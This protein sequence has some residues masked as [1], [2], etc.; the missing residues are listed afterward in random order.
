MSFRYRVIIT[1]ANGS[2][3]VKSSDL[4][5]NTLK[6]GRGTNCDIVVESR[7]V[8]LVH[9]VFTIDQQGVW[10]EDAGSL[11]GVQVDGVLVKRQ[12]LR[13]G[14]VVTLADLSLRIDIEDERVLVEQRIDR[15]AL[16]SPEQSLRENVAR[17]DFAAKLPIPWKIAAGVTLA[18]IL[19]FFLYP[20]RRQTHP[21]WVAG[22]SS[23][24]HAFFQR[25]CS[26]CHD[27]NFSRVSD[28]K[29]SSCHEMKQHAAAFHNPARKFELQ[30]KQGMCVDCH[31]EHSGDRITVKDSAL[32]SSCHSN[33]QQS[34]PDS[35]LVSFSDFGAH[36]EFAITVTQEGKRSFVRLDTS[37]RDPSETKFNHKRH[38]SEPIEGPQGKRSLACQECHEGT[39]K[40][41]PVSFERHC[42]S[43][44]SLAFDTSLPDI[45]APHAAPDEV[46]SSLLK[47]YSLST[48]AGISEH[49][50]KQRPIPGSPAQIEE[51]RRVA[52]AVALSSARTA[53]T[54]LFT[55]TACAVC[56]QVAERAERA[57]GDGSRF[58]VRSA[59]ITS[60]W[61]TRAHFSHAAHE[62]LQCQG[63]HQ[64][65]MESEHTSELHMPSIKGCRDCHSSLGGDGT[66][67]SDCVMCHSYH[68]PITLPE[69]KKIGN[70]VYIK[71]FKHSSG[72]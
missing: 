47:H 3:E 36:P 31:R 22:P 14:A 16:P 69:A 40:F 27:G 41:A 49:S 71:H 45:E 12:L 5:Q 64:G 43:C 50:G 61:F 11:A 34:V 15:R 24:A 65:I 13:R 35:S 23:R 9:A 42:H 44:H 6:V 68:T 52:R 57:N 54:Q 26:A 25:D 39:G 7:L 21:G 51:T 72:R 20:L 4:N 2:E 63:C 28:K 18:G 46:F 62:S 10:I 66:I 32:C 67:R 60:E 48:L 37:P 30:A 56:H 38:L 70:S 55:K 33:I 19:I 59:E 17:L 8:S 1:E 29:C 58:E 53:E